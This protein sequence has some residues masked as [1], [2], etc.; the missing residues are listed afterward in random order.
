MEMAYLIMQSLWTK[1]R[2]VDIKN[3]K[4]GNDNILKVISNEIHNHYIYDKKMDNYAWRV[5]E[6]AKLL[7]MIK[8]FSARERE[9]LLIAKFLNIFDCTMFDELTSCCC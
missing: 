3:G 9:I 6:I 4:T 5:A 1:K 7:A 8:E 2:A